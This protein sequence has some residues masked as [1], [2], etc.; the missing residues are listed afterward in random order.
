M[1]DSISILGGKGKKGATEPVGRLDLAMGDVVS[2]VGP[3]GSG[4]TTLI[5]DI[6]LFADGSTPT[7]RRILVNGSVPAAEYRDDP[8]KN[9]IALITQHTTFLSDLPVGEFL[10]TH[11]RIRGI[12][13]AQSDAIVAETLTFANELT[14]EAIALGS[15]MTELSGGQTRSLLIADATIVCN[16]PIVLLDEVE[17]AG[18]HRTRALELLR[19]YRKIFIFVTHDPRIALLSDYRVVM[20]GGEITKVLPTDSTEQRL[21][22]RVT[23][24]DDIL[25]RL[26]DRSRMG[27]R[28]QEAELEG[29]A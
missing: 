3:T 24:L 29:W 11:A 16:T 20:Q 19:R 10:R 2:I 22:T 28:L 17:N 6:E 13:G 1:I 5:N 15:R 25:S 23:R 18:I 27:E 7:G 8:A 12:A 14:G 26:R 21:A 4:K 9:P